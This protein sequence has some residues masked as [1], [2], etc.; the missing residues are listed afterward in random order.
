[1]QEVLRPPPYSV[2]ADFD[3]AVLS[4]VDMGTKPAAVKT[5]PLQFCK[6]WMQLRSKVGV[7]ARRL[8]WQQGHAAPS[9]FCHECTWRL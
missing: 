2:P 8:S 9:H 1:M 6:R 7:D 5:L 4:K 3:A